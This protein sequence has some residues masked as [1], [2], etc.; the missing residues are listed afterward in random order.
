MIFVFK[1]F[2]YIFK[3]VNSLKNKKH[4]IYQTAGFEPT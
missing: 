3:K 1:D 2:E 4:G